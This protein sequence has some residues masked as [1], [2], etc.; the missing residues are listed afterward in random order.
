M[1]FKE[2]KQLLNLGKSE[3][4]DF[5]AQIADATITMIQ[6]IFLSIRNRIEKYES[7]GKLYQNTKAETLE[8][9]LHERLIILLIAVL[10]IIEELFEDADADKLFVRMIN[11]ETVFDRIK[12][13][14]QPLQNDFKKAA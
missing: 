13:L 8:I 6:Y 1:F 5:D 2:A 11:D 7:I 10:E 12:L 9:Q 3:S 4:Q 14:L